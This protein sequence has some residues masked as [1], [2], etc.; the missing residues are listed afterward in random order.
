MG[1]RFRKLVAGSC[2]WMALGCSPSCSLDTFI[3][4][5]TSRIN[6]V[7]D[8]FKEVLKNGKASFFSGNYKKALETWAKSN[9]DFP[10]CFQTDKWR[11][12][13]LLMMDHAEQSY[14]LLYPYLKILPNHPELLL[15][16]GKCQFELGNYSKAV[17]LLEKGSACVAGIAGIYL[18]RADMYYHVGLHTKAGKYKQIAQLLLNLEERS[19][20]SHETH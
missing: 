11:A 15:L 6:S 8:N 3:N 12:R 4:N 20:S 14:N 5:K 2:M 17:E 9:V 13:A 18:T 19:N 16:L 7:P 1:S 10:Y